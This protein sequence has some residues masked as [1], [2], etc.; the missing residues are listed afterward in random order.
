MGINAMYCNYNESE[1]NTHHKDHYIEK[2]TTENSINEVQ[3]KY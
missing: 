1:R 3:S 2:H